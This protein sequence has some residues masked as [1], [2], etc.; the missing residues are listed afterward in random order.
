MGISDRLM[1]AWNAFTGNDLYDNYDYSIGPSYGLR[2]YSNH[3]YISNDRSIVT[4]V[5]NQIA[6][7]VAAIE[8]RHVKLDENDRYTEDIS[9]GLNY[10]LTE[11]ANIDQ[12]GV[13]FRQDIAMTV[14]EKGVAAVVPVDT[15]INPRFTNGYDIKTLRV[16][17]VVEWFPEHVRVDLYNDRKGVR[18]Q[19][20]LPKTMVAIIQ[21]PL[22]AIMNEPNSIL[23]RLL[24]KL[25]LMD[26]MDEQVAANNLDMIIKL[27]Y[28]VK[29]E[30]RRKQAEQRRNDIEF[31][32]KSS[33]YGVAYVDGT[34][35]IVQLNRPIENNFYKTVDGL[36]DRLYFSLGLTKGILDGTANE[37][38]M[39]NYMNRTVKPIVE[40]IR[41]SMKRTFL[42]KTARTQKQSIVSITDPFKLVPINNIAEI[43]DKF[44]RNEILSSNEVRSLIGFRPSSDPKADELRNSNMPVDKAGLAPPEQ[45]PEPPLE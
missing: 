26:K 41:Q 18:E 16:G 44:T 12:S 4:N 20:I 15:D 29:S 3:S 35:E 5:L 9:S 42:S 39:L 1:H 45:V 25:A 6:V 24:R 2:Q 30:S 38:E 8:L 22:Y 17:E 21:N 19:I 7:D 36:T 43:A 14:L 40:S 13:D 27:P 11:E 34:E 33:Q 23:Q 37:Q 28:V 31:Q 32:L 10:C